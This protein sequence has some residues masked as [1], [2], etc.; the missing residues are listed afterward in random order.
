LLKTLTPVT[1]DVALAIQE[2]LSSRLQ[3]ADRL[4]EQ[5]VERA[6]YE[7]ELARQRYMQVDPGNRFVAD[8]LEADWNEKLRILAQV[9]ENCERQQAEDRIRME[10]E[11]RSR[12][13]ALATD[14]PR[15]W[16]DSKT[17][18]RDRKRMVRLLLEDVTLIKG[19]QITMHVR[20]KGGFTTS[21]T[22]KLPLRA[23][24]IRQTPPE[25]VKE[26]D[27]SLN[28]STEAQIAKLLNDKGLRSGGGQ[29]F[30]S[31]LGRRTAFSFQSCLKD[32]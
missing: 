20:F 26:I 12:I 23:W 32:S 9:K 11:E 22:L 27:R 1:L 5:Q 8:S 21:M 16:K 18:D 6:R 13:M 31:S 10:G 14:F 29:P 17:S 4:R 7:T 24:E 2:E 25:V 19:G 15:L 28:Q 3:E 30:H